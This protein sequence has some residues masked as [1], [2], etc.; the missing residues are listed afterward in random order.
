MK[1]GAR[2]HFD[3]RIDHIRDGAINDEIELAV[4]DGVRIVATVT[5]ESCEQIELKVGAPAFAPVKASRIVI[6]ARKA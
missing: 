4:A 2:N 6:G 1:T 5:R 3:G